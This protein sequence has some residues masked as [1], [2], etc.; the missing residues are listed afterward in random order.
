VVERAISYQD[1]MRASES[2]CCWLPAVLA[3]LVRD[4]ESLGS[5][6]PYF[7]SRP[8]LDKMYHSWTEAIEYKLKIA[9]HVDRVKPR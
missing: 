6:E 7:P 1:G 9:D 8:L 2:N 4:H 3:D 5:D